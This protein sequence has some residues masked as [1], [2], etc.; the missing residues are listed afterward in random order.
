[1][2]SFIGALRPPPGRRRDVLARDRYIRDRG[3]QRLSLRTFPRYHV[4]LSHRTD[5]FPRHGA[6]GSRVPR[7]PPR[8]K[9]RSWLRGLSRTST[10]SRGPAY[11]KVTL[12]FDWGS[13]MDLLS[14]EV[15]KKSIGSFFPRNGEP[16]RAPLRSFPSTRSSAGAHR[17]DDLGDIRRLADQK[18]NRISRRSSVSPPRR[19]RAVS[20]T[21]SRSTSIRN[22]S[23]AGDPIDRIRQVCRCF[24]REPPGRKPL[25]GPEDSQFSSGRSPSSAR[26]R[27]SGASSFSRTRTEWSGL[28]R[29]RLWCG[30]IQGTRGDHARRRKE[31]VEIALYKEGD[32]NTVT[33]AQIIRDRSTS[34]GRSSHPATR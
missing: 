18:I 20:R 19:S 32:A 9:R 4:S 7:N 1:M 3:V 23:P 13:D 11:P 10:R 28:S 14:M 27:R 25:R 12:E 15:A 6:A 24:E 2:R 22:A 8:R 31:C 17:T 21:R 29:R 30:W 34:G 5:G 26:W 33:V 16:N